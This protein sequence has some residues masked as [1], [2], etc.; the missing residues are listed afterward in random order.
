M[1]FERLIT[2]KGFFLDDL[3]LPDTLY[4]H[5]IRSAYARARVERV[6]G[7]INASEFNASLTSVG[8]GAFTGKSFVAMHAFASERVN[9]FGEPVAAVLGRTPYEAADLAESVEVDYEPLKPVLTIEDALSSEPIHSGTNSNVLSSYELGNRF[10]LDSPIVLED[11]LTNERVLPNPLET[12]GI[13][14]YY[15]GSR[16]N[17]WIP[18]QSV[19]SIKQGLC[20]SLSLPPEM[21]RVIQLDTGGAF[22][23]KSALY[24]EYVIAAYATLKT[25]KPVK[26]VEK[27]SEHLSATFPGRGSKA[28]IKLYAQRSGK[29]QGVEAE[30]YTDAGAYFVGLNA[31]AP[32][33][34]G[35]QITGVYSIRNVHV[36]ALAVYTN[37]TPLGPYRGAGRPE[38]TFFIERM[39]DKLADELALDDDKVRLLNLSHESFTSPT[40]LKLEPATRFFKG[41][42]ETLGYSKKAGLSFFVLFPAVQPG[43]SAKIVVKGGRIRVWLGGNSHGQAHEVFVKSILSKELEVPESVIEVERGDTDALSRG[44]GSW[45]SRSALVG[46]AALIEAARKLKEKAKEGVGETLTSGRY[47]PQNLLKGEFE[48]EVFKELKEQFNSFGANLVE[49]EVDETGFVRIK[50][51]ASYY[52][53]GKALNPW[54]VESQIIGGCAQAIAQVLYERALYSQ[55]GALLVSSIADAGVPTVEDLPQNYVIHLVENPSPLP[56]GA[57]GVGESATIGVPPALVRALEKALKVRFTKTPISWEDVYRAQQKLVASQV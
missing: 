49:L 45:G 23:T 32:S 55:D 37:K 17:I 38:A 8:E 6:K 25:K 30:I 10:K 14:A 46:G 41:A 9:F 22:G 16:L 18:T 24:P 7:G 15:D 47:T 51:C 29:V 2:G 21:V 43:E 5:V 27:R 40:G 34:I 35:F 19:Y 12:R 50:K 28:R 57:K 4:L 44:V 3:K 36:K 31:F 48:V 20:A 1:S 33:F 13:V 52:D 26:W 42:L 39:M 56:H 54:M 53:V 11:T